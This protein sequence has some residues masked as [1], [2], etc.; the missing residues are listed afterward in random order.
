[1]YNRNNITLT[2]SS[3]LR[4]VL[5]AHPP[6]R[7]IWYDERISTEVIQHVELQPHPDG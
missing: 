6:G 4:S 7:K 3:Y 5:S 2:H 1:M